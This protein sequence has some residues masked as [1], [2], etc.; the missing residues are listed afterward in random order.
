MALWG[1]LATVGWNLREHRAGRPTICSR[2]RA[3][4]PPWLFLILWRAFSRWM[5][6]HIIDGYK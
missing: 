6:R 4:V 5:E 2:T 1:L 3:V